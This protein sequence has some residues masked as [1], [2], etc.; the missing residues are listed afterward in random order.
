MILKETCVLENCIKN[1]FFLKKAFQDIESIYLHTTYLFIHSYAS[2]PYA[3]IEFCSG[4]A[5]RDSQ[6]NTTQNSLY[7]T[8]NLVGKTDFSRNELRDD[9]YN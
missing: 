2:I 6:E 4:P 7:E 9:K 8:H 3:F 1:F 5:I